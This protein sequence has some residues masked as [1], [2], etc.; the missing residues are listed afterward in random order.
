M[1]KLEPCPFCGAE[2]ALYAPSKNDSWSVVCE[3]EGVE[4]N[5]RLLYCLTREEAVQQWNRR[6]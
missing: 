3:N 5:V 6:V 4:C 1:D 2:A